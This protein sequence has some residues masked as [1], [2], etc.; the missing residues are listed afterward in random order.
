MLE[1]IEIYAKV[2]QKREMEI[3]QDLYHPCNKVEFTEKQIK[4]MTNKQKND[5]TCHVNE[6]ISVP[7][8][9]ENEIYDVESNIN[10]LETKLMKNRIL[11]EGEISLNIIFQSNNV[12]KM[13]AKNYKLPFRH[14]VEMQDIEGL[15]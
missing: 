3:I 7:E 10:I 9:N 14:E 13:N 8:I 11:Y 15:E 1:E 6:K 12:A 4:T 5:N 2:Y